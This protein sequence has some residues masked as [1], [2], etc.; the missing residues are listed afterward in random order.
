MKRNFVVEK[1]I[2]LYLPWLI[3]T[4]FQHDLVF[5]YLAAWLGSFFIFFMTLTG[6][7]V[8]LP[9]DRSFA[10]QIMRP[11]VLVQ[12]IFAGY[13]CCTSIFYFMSLFGYNNFQAVPYYLVDEHK[14]QLTAQCQR[15]YCL[16]HAAV[17]TGMLAFMRYPKPKY[18]IETAK[19][20][21]LLF[22]TTILSFPL[23]IFFLEFPG[24][25]QFSTQFS[26]LSFMSSALGL[27]FV[28]PQKKAFNIAVCFFFYSLNFY[29]A[30]TSGFKE[31][32]ILS[33]LVLGLFLYPVYKK[34]V[35]IVF[36]PML[37]LLFLVL[38]TYVN[39]IRQ[40]SW[41]GEEDTDV[42]ASEALDVAID[43][44]ATAD[45][46][47]WQFLTNRLSEIDMFTLF[48][49]STPDK[50][51]YYH[52]QLLEQ[53]AIALIPRIFWPGKASTE[54][55]VMQ[56]VYDAGV[57]NQYS[58]V[59]AKPAFVVD[60]YLSW[61][62]WGVF[63]FLFLYGAAAQIIS[64]KAESLFGGYILGTALVF[65]GLFQIFWRG[66]SFEFL[67]NNIFWGY[68]SMLVLAGILRR[69]NILQPA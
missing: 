35:L 33:I 47:T 61:G 45:E 68:I 39:V 62:G 38:P 44:G 31:P 37:L 26:S 52:F 58:K 17:V 56:R 14:L 53:S 4:I 64:R 60:A 46:T 49:E 57:I 30:L 12:I 24:L 5:S 3:A 59:S 15:Y 29:I 27:A 23:A 1:F 41:S 63:I 36:V 55:V 11:I 48:I 32:I 7:I 69:M 8:P 67:A 25:G 51:D 50:V 2:L 10:N 40:N 22:Y 65:S 34:I 42:A 9:D 18:K 20:T 16:G 43:R 28:I 54:Q 13:M 6:Q 19:L 66:L 21:S